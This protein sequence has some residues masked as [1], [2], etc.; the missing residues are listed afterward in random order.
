MQVVTLG[1]CI[2]IAELMIIIMI[3]IIMIVISYLGCQT[4][5]SSVLRAM[6]AGSVVDWVYVMIIIVIIISDAVR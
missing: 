3:I 2:P 5:K 6:T 1:G 4:L